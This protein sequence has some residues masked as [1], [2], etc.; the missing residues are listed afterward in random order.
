MVVFTKCFQSEQVGWYR[1]LILHLYVV[2]DLTWENDFA[3]CGS[4]MS[5]LRLNTPAS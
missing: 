4:M 2:L 1:K 3:F 5:F